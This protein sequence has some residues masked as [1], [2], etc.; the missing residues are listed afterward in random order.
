MIEVGRNKYF[1]NAFFIYLLTIIVIVILGFGIYLT[2]QR[3]FLFSRKIDSTPFIAWDNITSGGLASE[4]RK[5]Y[6]FGLI[7]RFSRFAEPFSVVL[8]PNEVMYENYGYNFIG[9]FAKDIETNRYADPAKRPFK[10]VGFLR[11]E[12]GGEPYLVVV[13]HWLNRDGG[14][15]FLPLVIAL[16]AVEARPELRQLLEES[17][18]GTAQKFLSPIVNIRDEV[19]CGRIVAAGPGY[20]SWFL[21]LKSEIMPLVRT[22]VDSGLVPRELETMPL[23][24]TFSPLIYWGDE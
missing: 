15:V 18:S 13:Q 4:L 22:W 6:Y 9:L 16:E 24:L 5:A 20:C 14:R 23:M 12:I 8:P 21:S 7:G 1:H 17:V 10:A 3:G 11:T 2:H 19:S